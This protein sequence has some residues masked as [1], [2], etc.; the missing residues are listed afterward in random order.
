MALTMRSENE[1]CEQIDQLEFEIA[2]LSLTK[3]NLYFR[4]A[5][6]RRDELPMR[7]SSVKM[8]FQLA[9][10]TVAYTKPTS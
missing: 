9:T 6:A 7:M 2:H 8:Q 4:R 5:L 1:H 10:L 3:A